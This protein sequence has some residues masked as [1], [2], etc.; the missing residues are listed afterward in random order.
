MGL[1]DP[2]G[3]WLGN[4]SGSHSRIWRLPVFLGLLLLLAGVL[5]GD[6]F[7]ARIGG[8]CWGLGHLWRWSEGVRR[9][10]PSLRCPPTLMSMSAPA[11][12]GR[13]QL[14]R[15]LG[16]TLGL[17]AVIGVAALTGMSFGFGTFAWAWLVHFLLMIWILA[18]EAVASLP[19]EGRWYAVRAWEPP[20][21]R[22]LGVM[23]FMRL[24]RRVGW[25]WANRGAKKFD[26]TRA[27]LAAYE[28]GTRSSE[29]NHAV[30]AA[31]GFVL[32]L[33]SVLLRA[34][35]AAFWLLAVN[36]FLHVY[37]V[38]LQRTMRAR[39][40]GLLERADAAPR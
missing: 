17:F 29:F 25:E 7:L 11:S 16:M 8:V 33:G 3:R 28:R 18:L 36:L 6:G 32:V 1:V 30:L 24:L 13:G 19:Y 26:G 9:P 38:M 15:W 34:W 22:R 39:V 23:G 27:S 31:V 21:Y 40:S 14:W 35:E 4:P 10:P 12:P 5:L 2:L 20:L 37:P